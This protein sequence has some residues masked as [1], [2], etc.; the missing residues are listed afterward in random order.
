[1]PLITDMKDAKKTRLDIATSGGTAQLSL[2]KHTKGCSNPKM[3][4][5]VTHGW[6]IA[7]AATESEPHTG[8]PAFAFLVP[9]GKSLERTRADGWA[10]QAA[11]K[12]AS[13]P[14]AFATA[15]IPKL[16]VGAHFCDTSD[17]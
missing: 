11:R 13:A 2:F 17:R 6:Q 10:E 1:M 3:L 15:G 8:T 16:V 14:L 12:F 5:L 7:P 9:L 4:M